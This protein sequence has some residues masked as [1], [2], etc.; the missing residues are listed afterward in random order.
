MV[1]LVKAD[2]PNDELFY[3]V[4]SDVFL[5]ILHWISLEDLIKKVTFAVALREHEKLQAINQVKTKVEIQGGKV[6]VCEFDIEQCSSTQIKQTLK[7]GKSIS[8]CV[9]QDVIDYINQHK[10]YQ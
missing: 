8:D 6:V 4:G 7:A 5:S 3:I 1:D 9:H 2:Y 10:T